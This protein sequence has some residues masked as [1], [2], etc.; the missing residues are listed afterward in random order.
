MITF[1]RGYYKDIA[2]ELIVPKILEA[3]LAAG[4]EVGEI[5]LRLHGETIYEAPLVALAD[6]AEAGMFAQ[7]S[8]FVTLF[9]SQLFSGE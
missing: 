9:F 2:A 1:P 8:D 5:K 7:L 3:P 6:V 4:Q